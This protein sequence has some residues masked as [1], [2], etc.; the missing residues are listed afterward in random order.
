MGA[1]TEKYYFFRTVFNRFIHHAS[2]ICIACEIIFVFACCFIEHIKAFGSAACIPYP[3][4]WIISLTAADM[5]EVHLVDPMEGKVY[6]IPESILCRDDFGALVFKALPI[7]DYP[8]FLIFG[9]I[10]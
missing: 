5:G 9:S 8:L 3:A 6:D 10:E 1:V 7:R 4:V 2:C